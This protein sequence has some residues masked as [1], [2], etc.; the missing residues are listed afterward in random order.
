MENESQP[1]YESYRERVKALSED[2]RN[3]FFPFADYA[4]GRF[5]SYIAQGPE[6]FPEDPAEK[7]AAVAA[8]RQAAVAV[9]FLR[10][11][12]PLVPQS[13]VVN[14]LSELVARSE[15]PGTLY[16]LT[17]EDGLPTIVDYSLAGSGSS[18]ITTVT[19]EAF[20]AA[21]R[22]ERTRASMKF[23]GHPWVYVL[24]Y[25]P[26]PSISP[27]MPEPRV[28]PPSMLAQRGH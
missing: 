1:S 15:G 22:T 24:G 13:A 8:L 5:G 3:I 16:F 12:S 27:L 6:A 9:T 20:T 23:T 28:V 21:S 18:F 7:Q 4:T 10:F 17:P 26:M 19:Q 2:P 14:S 11:G 25:E